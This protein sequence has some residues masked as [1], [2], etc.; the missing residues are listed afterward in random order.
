MEGVQAV[1]GQLNAV[2]KEYMQMLNYNQSVEKFEDETVQNEKEIILDSLPPTTDENQMHIQNV[3][4][5]A[6]DN[7]NSQAFMRLWSEHIPEKL[8]EENS[9][10]RLEFNIQ[11]YFAVYPMRQDAVEQGK[12]DKSMKMFKSFLETRGASLS[13]T[14]EFVTFYALPF[15]PA[16]SLGTHPS[17]SVL[18]QDSWTDDLRKKLQDFLHTVLYSAPIGSKNRSKTEL[19]Q[20]E[21]HIEALQQQISEHE[22]RATTYFKRY[23]K[24]QADYRNLINIAAELVD[25]LENAVRG[26]MVSPEYLHEICERLFKNGQN[27]MQSTTD[28]T[29]PGTAGSMLRASIN[30]FQGVAIG[31][32]VP[33]LPSLNYGQIKEDLRRLTTRKKALLLQALRLAISPGVVACTCNPA[34]WRLESQDGLSSGP[35]VAACLCRSDVRAKPDVNMRLLKATSGEQRDA[36]VS[37]YVANDILG[38]S[39]DIKHAETI[40]N[41]LNSKEEVLRDQTAMFFN[42]VASFT[43]G[44]AYIGHSEPMIKEIIN[45]LKKESEKTACGENLLG[46][47]QKLSLRRQVQTTM[48]NCDLVDWLLMILEEPESLSDYT[49][50]YSVALLM[51]LCLRSEGK[52]KCL[53]DCENVLKLLADLL[54]HENKEIRPY[55][56][57]TLYSILAL[58]TIRQK[59]VSMGLE[60][61]LRCYLQDDDEDTN[62]QI[63][64]II[65]QMNTNDKTLSDDPYS[66][67][68]DDDDDEEG[69]VVDAELDEDEIDIAKPGELSGE[70]LL[71]AHYL[72]VLSSLT[73]PKA[74]VNKTVADLA[75]QEVPLHRPVTPRAQPKLNSIQERP[76]REN[77]RSGLQ[78]RGERP[79]TQ[80]SGAQSRGSRGRD[81]AINEGSRPS[82]IRDR[83][84][85]NRGNAAKKADPFQTKPKIPRTPEPSSGYSTPMSGIVRPTSFA[86]PPPTK[87]VSP[88][89]PRPSSKGQ[90]EIAACL[91]A[92]T[93]PCRKFTKQHYHCHACLYATER[94]DNFKRHIQYHI[95]SDNKERQKT[96]DCMK[97]IC[98]EYFTTNCNN[99]EACKFRNKAFM[100]FHCSLCEFTCNKKKSFKYRLGHLS[101]RHNLF[102]NDLHQPED[103]SNPKVQK[104]MK[105]LL[106]LG[107]ATFLPGKCSN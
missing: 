3:I 82:S 38:C 59:A 90:Q 30:N 94:L 48:I 20:Y 15:V 73:V 23:T 86:A 95:S 40:V 53:P 39:S 2:V 60:E 74:A 37:S 56:N 51:N 10:Q 16:A 85:S 46:G 50:E 14:T 45:R 97:E 55:V 63:N 8:Q 70:Q 18:F 43:A 6:F 69:D 52:K 13:Q 31:S 100:H 25:A 49:L 17:F 29:R 62:R 106:R 99:I 104:R 5:Q 36:A 9:C 26:Q 58:A 89:L 57:G 33:Y 61:V 7:G 72:G 34:A 96:P 91:S 81:S 19:K 65:K 42:T 78:S 76:S 87:S 101:S 102:F 71:S 75:S 67:T 103:F 68:E 79:K 28:F 93:Q 66:D 44:R 47:M 21:N 105:R 54:G 98:N 27:P 11:L 41:L 1:E 107:L 35:L 12:A 64:F 32:D 80:S 88:P 92:C 22:H 83:P 4:L 84:S 24:I 77:A